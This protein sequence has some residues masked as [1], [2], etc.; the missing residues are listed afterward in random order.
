MPLSAPTNSMMRTKE[1]IEADPATFVSHKKKNVPEIVG[2]DE[3]ENI[4]QMSKSQ[5]SSTSGVTAKRRKNNKKGRRKEPETIIEEKDEDFA[6]V[7]IH[8]NKDEGASPDLQKQYSHIDS[9]S[10]PLKLMS[11]HDQQS[12]KT[13]NSM[14]SHYE[15]QPNKDKQNIDEAQLTTLSDINAPAKTKKGEPTNANGKE[16]SG[17]DGATSSVTDFGGEPSNSK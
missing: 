8:S 3:D 9:D 13:P 6:E 5:V 15:P 12:V 11:Q 17:K 1:E 2:E 10:S 16:L 7:E 14:K 4:S